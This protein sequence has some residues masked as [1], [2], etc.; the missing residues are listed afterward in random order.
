M[1]GIGI[2]RRQSTGACRSP[3][4]PASVCVRTRAY[5]NGARNRPPG[6]AWPGFCPATSTAREP[7]PRHSSS[8]AKRLRAAAATASVGTRMRERQRF[9]DRARRMVDVAAMVDRHDAHRP[10]RR[11]SQAGSM[12]NAA[13]A[14]VT[15]GDLPPDDVSRREGAMPPPRVRTR[16][17]TS[18]IARLMSKRGCRHTSNRETVA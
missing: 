16:A 4:S 8:R 12:A 9:N 10:V 7:Y 1:A 18:S 15:R 5:R 3:Q 17:D 2:A 11:R 14:A 6:G 13:T